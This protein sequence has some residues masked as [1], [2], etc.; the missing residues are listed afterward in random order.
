M[1][2]EITHDGVVVKTDGREVSVMIVQTSACSG[3]HAKG[4]CMASDKDEK[5]IVADSAGQTF[6]PGDQVTLVGSNSMAWSALAY[7]F[8]LPTVLAMA[9][10]FA[11]ASFWGEGVAALVVLAFLGLYFFVL[12]LFRDKM[13]T[14][15]T[16]RVEPKRPAYVPE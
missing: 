5:I 1:S 15:F 10:L 4:A 14:A 7:A 13:K 11:A 2:K 9:V 12:W 3:C 16:F 8:V 6:R